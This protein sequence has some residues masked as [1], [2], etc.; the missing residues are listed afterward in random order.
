MPTDKVAVVPQTYWKILATKIATGDAKLS[1]SDMTDITGYLDFERIIFISSSSKDLFGPLKTRAEAAEK[2]SYQLWGQDRKYWLSREQYWLEEIRQKN[3]ITEDDGKDQISD[4]VSLDI[5]VRI[6]SLAVLYYKTN[7]L[8]V[9]KPDTALKFRSAALRS[10]NAIIENAV[11][12][13]QLRVERIKS[14]FA[15]GT[16]SMYTAMKNAGIPSGSS[17]EYLPYPEKMLYEIFTWLHHDALRNEVC[18]R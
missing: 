18:I 6:Y 11:N 10:V 2:L 7:D 17:G 15:N 12:N 5:L 9:S 3:G 13:G 16:V 14:P 1:H 8:I 4:V